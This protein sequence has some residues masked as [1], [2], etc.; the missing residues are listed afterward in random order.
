MFFFLILLEFSIQN[1][2]TKNDFRDRS[3]LRGHYK[4][5]AS[6]SNGGFMA[7]ARD[8]VFFN[9]GEFSSPFG[10]NIYSNQSDIYFG[11]GSCR[12]YQ[13]MNVKFRQIYEINTIRIRFWDQATRIYYFKIFATYKEDSDEVQIYDGNA[14]GLVTIN[15]S[16]RLVSKI[17]IY[18]LGNNSPDHIQDGYTSI[19]KVQAYFF[20]PSEKWKQMI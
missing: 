19:I 8:I 11:Y 20:M 3:I 10:N 18:S 6:D 12:R 17:R 9:Y 13:S 7:N 4:D 16:A 2:C 1:T 14:I 15:F 5:V